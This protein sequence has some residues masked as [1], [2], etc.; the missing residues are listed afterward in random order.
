LPILAGGATNSGLSK[1]Q[2]FARNSHYTGYAHANISHRSELTM[3]VSFKC[4]ACGQELEVDAS[5]AGSEIDCPSC[6]T[7]I[8]V[9]SPEPGDVVLVEAVA[10][11]VA[12]PAP[13]EPPHEEKH[14]S[15]PVRENSN[16]ELLIKKA[17][18]PL[19]VA[20]K[21]SDKTL[22]IKSVKR[23]D[24]QEV[25]RDRFDEI[26]SCFL[27]KVGQTNIVSVSPINYSYLD[28]TTR[29]ILTDYGVMIVYRG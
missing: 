13:A 20:A 19:D 18:K 6:S 14:F 2:D 11:V 29:T 23:S 25:G 15:V 24:C 8:T 21:E 28:L 27:D 5:A 22:R 17:N 7:P 12:A 26:V 4:S 1:A 16:S 9:P 10:V 3:D